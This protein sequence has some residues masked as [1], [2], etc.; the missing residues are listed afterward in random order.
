MRRLS[1][2]IPFLLIIFRTDNCE[3]FN[4]LAIS[5]GGTWVLGYSFFV[6]RSCSCSRMTKTFL[7]FHGTKC[8]KSLYTSLYLSFV[9]VLLWI[10]FPY[11]I[12]C[13]LFFLIMLDNLCQ[14]KLLLRY[15]HTRC[16]WN[17]DRLLISSLNIIMASKI[18]AVK[19]D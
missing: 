17:V 19:G 6:F 10:I 5:F 15:S 16:S 3:I 7:S 1:Y 14:K 13:V 18:N 8:F 4:P 9:L 11:F 2:F 12:C